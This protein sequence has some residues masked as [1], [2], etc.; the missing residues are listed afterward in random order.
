M[1]QWIIAPSVRSRPKRSLRSEPIFSYEL[2][3]SFSETTRSMSLS[4]NLS[5]F[6]PP[7]TFGI[8]GETC[9]PQHEQYL[10]FTTYSVVTTFAGTMSST[11][12][13]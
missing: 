12:L 2:P 11:T 7:M 10:L 13:V 1:T 4:P 6:P 8:G 3:R 5:F 9:L